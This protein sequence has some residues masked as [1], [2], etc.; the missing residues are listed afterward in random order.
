MFLAYTNIVIL[1]HFCNLDNHNNVFRAIQ[2][3]YAT[4]I[5]FHHPNFGPNLEPQNF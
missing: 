2:L 4:F 1:L 5:H 3:L